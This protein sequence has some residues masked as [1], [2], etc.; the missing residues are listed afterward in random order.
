MI[1][2]N[3]ARKL[4]EKV[5]ENPAIIE[6]ERAEQEICKAVYKGEGMCL[7]EWEISESALHILRCHGFCIRNDNGNAIIIWGF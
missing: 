1:T 2:A 6:V 4:V 7:I 5:R 3:E